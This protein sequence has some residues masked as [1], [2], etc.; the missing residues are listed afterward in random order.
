MILKDKSEEKKAAFYK[1]VETR[2]EKKEKEGCTLAYLVPFMYFEA[3]NYSPWT[4]ASHATHV[5]EQNSLD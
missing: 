3:T 1:S 4:V 5:N 2:R